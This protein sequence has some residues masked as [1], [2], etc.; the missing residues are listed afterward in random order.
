MENLRIED[1]D[2]VDYN[3]VLAEKV[4]Y[5]DTVIYRYYDTPD[6]TVNTCNYDTVSDWV[7]AAYRRMRFHDT[8]RSEHPLFT[9]KRDFQCRCWVQSC[10]SLRRLTRINPGQ[11]HCFFKKIGQETLT[12]LNQKGEWPRW[13]R[14]CLCKPYL[15]TLIIKVCYPFAQ[16][17]RFSVHR[18]RT[19]YVKRFSHRYV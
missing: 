13:Q 16:I 18:F 7:L 6:S 3:I 2:Y 11:I 8:I 1:A 9:R 19:I 15:A 17:G 12:Y 4:G 10:M 14:L 5:L